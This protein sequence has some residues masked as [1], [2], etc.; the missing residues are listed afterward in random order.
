MPLARRI[1]TKLAV[2]FETRKESTNDD[3][4][5]CLENTTSPRLYSRLDNNW[6]LS[7][8]ICHRD[9][10]QRASSA[11]MYRVQRYISDLNSTNKQPRHR[12]FNR[13]PE[14]Q[15]PDSAP[16][17]AAL[18]PS[19]D[20]LSKLQSF[21]FK[22]TM[23]AEQSSQEAMTEVEHPATPMP[24]K[25]PLS[26]LMSNTPKRQETVTDESPEDKVVWKITPKKA[27][28][29]PTASQESQSDKMTTF[30]SLLKDDDTA[31]KVGSS[32]IR[33]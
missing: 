22:P 29:P 24:Q 18:R 16:S 25:I 6:S 30:L 31:K 5:S 27:I 26:D 7:S 33:R 1:I 14:R 17:F 8:T 3:F 9:I 4:K 32:H 19:E 12:N 2:A 21:A 15:I 23:S 20:T 11:Q 10:I 13:P 28:A